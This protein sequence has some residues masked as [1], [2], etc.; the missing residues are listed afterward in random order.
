MTTTT[1]GGPGPSP[2]DRRKVKALVWMRT[3]HHQVVDQGTVGAFRRRR[4]PTS[5]MPQLLRACGQ[6][7][8]MTWLPKELLVPDVI[9]PEGRLPKGYAAKYYGLGKLVWWAYNRAPIDPEVRWDPAFEWN[10]AFPPTGDG[11]E[12][13]TSD[14][15]FARLR[16]QGPNPWLLRRVE[17]HPAEGGGVEPVFEADY[18]P[19][20]DGILP[21]IVARFA[22][23]DGELVPTDITVGPG[24][25][26]PGDPT[27]DQAKRVANAADARF[28]AF[29]RHLLDTHLIVG[30]AFALA[31][32]SLPTWHRLRP[33]M[34]FFTY[35]T[36]DV[37][38]F[39]YRA[40]LAPGSYFVESGFAGIDDA[41]LL[42]TNMIARF[43]LDQWIAP[44]DIADRGLEAIPDHPYVQDAL[45][46]WPAFED[47]VARHLDELGLD[48]E[49]IAADKDLQTWYLTLAKILPH[50][51]PLEEPLDRVRLADLCTA[52]LWNNVVHEIC[53]DLSPILGSEDPLDKA[54]VNL[55]R[56][57]EAVADG[58]LT[59]PAAPPTMADVF[60]IDQ[61]SYVSRFN[62]G[63]NNILAINAAREVDDPKLRMAIEDLQATLGALERELVERN[64]AR[65]VRF[66]RMFPSCWEASVSF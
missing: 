58:D 49:A 52:L 12:H 55:G 48:D 43:D 25:H 40:L 46:V 29:G 23:R 20:F 35:G 24:R 41:R 57:R 3:K 62:V 37:N 9:P 33:F 1:P 31:A 60:L 6:Y 39:A 54:M 47:V 59:T 64:R 38:D 2:A 44:R 50:T 66:A 5:G 15:T 22:V 8:A 63:G 32:F 42:F 65:P 17:D 27:W 53:G 61:A 13:P 28:A 19:Y 26:H 45:L 4:V 10:H 51:D 11:W 18:T 14:A 56:F 30:A 21:P 16:L 36:L 7:P 34:Q